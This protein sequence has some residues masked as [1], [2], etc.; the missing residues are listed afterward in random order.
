M[1]TDLTSYRTRL[2]LALRERDVPGPQI[3]EALAEVES[4]VAETGEEPES[5]FGPPRQYADAVA[6]A[7]SE[8]GR[9]LGEGSWITW[10]RAAACGI[11]GYLGA[12]ALIDGAVGVSS[13]EPGVF[14][15]PAGLSLGAGVLVLALL[16]GFFTVWAR[17]ADDAVVDP[18][19]GRDMAPVVP[20]WAWA[21]MTAPL[22][23]AVAVAVALGWAAS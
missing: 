12:A 20:M 23:L 8:D 10:G 9:P 7:L 19:T 17:R 18:R 22:V 16:A 2:L 11:A 3:A 13:S 1:T 21:V 14:G 5:A 6:S 15:T 4:H